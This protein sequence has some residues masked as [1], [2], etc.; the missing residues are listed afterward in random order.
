MYNAELRN[1]IKQ[2]ILDRYDISDILNILAVDDD[3]SDFYDLIEEYILDRVNKFHL[4]C[5]KPEINNEDYY[6]EQDPEIEE[7]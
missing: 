2:E 6:E 5:L 3:I 7:W 4:D 1:C